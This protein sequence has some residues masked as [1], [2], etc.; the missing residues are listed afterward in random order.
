[1]EREKSAISEDGAARLMASS[2][3][4]GIGKVY[5]SR[6]TQEYGHDILR[7]LMEEPQTVEIKGLPQQKILAASQA[8]T[9]LGEQ[10]VRLMAFLYSCNVPEIFVDRILAKYRG[11]DA[12]KFLEDP[13]AMV[14]RVWRLTFFTA[15][16]IGKALGIE[17]ADIR[18]LKGA[19]LTSIK[20]FAEEGHLFATRDQTLAYAAGI[21]NVE[22]SAVLPAIAALIEEEAIVESRGGLYLPVYYFAEKEAAAYISAIAR[23]RIENIDESE[24]P[25]ADARGN[26]YSPRQMEGIRQLLGNPVSVLT[27]GPGTGK[28]TVLKGVLDVLDRQGR[29]VLL[30][31]PTGRAAKRMETLT[32]REASTIHRLLGY[33]EG[34]GYRN[35]RIDA[36]VLVI[37]EG[38]MLEQVLFYHLLEAVGE[39]VKLII[40]GDADQLPAIGAGNVLTDLISAGT[41]PVVELSENFRQK[42]GSGIA[43]VAR[44]INSG[45]TPLH[46]AS[47]A[48]NSD[49]VIVEEK[50]SR[51]F[52]RLLELVATQIPEQ[53][54]ISP[55]AI[56]V[57]TPQQMGPLGARAL[58][59]ALQE[60]LN[61]VGPEIRRVSGVMRLGDPVMQT[62]NSRLR[63]LYNGET[64]RICEV[65]ETQQSLTVEFS[66][67]RRSRYARSEL[68]ELTLAYATTVHKLQGSEVDYMVMP[69]TMAHKPMLYR[70]LLYTAVSRAKKLCVLLT[71]KEALDYAIANIPDFE[72]NSNFALRLQPPV[73]SPSGDFS[74]H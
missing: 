29:K 19:V 1:M 47:S 50:Q 62:A 26:A 45:E 71:D 10:K 20:H 21:A 40:V 24:I 57:V 56:Q 34:E 61:P 41:I 43:A 69:L 44:A 39:S 17:G 12:D 38:S 59:A 5:A 64:G 23:R 28:T 2:A 7:R 35:H 30:V 49:F 42:A 8:L 32:G 46:S 73:T 33:R 15:D 70:N 37:D 51:I 72:R 74:V 6:L 13:Y 48:E 65:D 67:G 53:Y 63:G 60:R 14:E 25:I 55:T 9:E 68:S 31:A 16:K 27:G 18:R 22:E 54:G 4:P 11:K 58:N 52:T 66:D 3:V 36:D